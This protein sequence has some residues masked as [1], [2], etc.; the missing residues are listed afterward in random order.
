MNSI[1]LYYSQLPA[2]SRTLPAFS[3]TRLP[4]DSPRQFLEKLNEAACRSRT[5]KSVKTRAKSAPSALQIAGPITGAA[6]AAAA[7]YAV[8]TVVRG[9]ISNTFATQ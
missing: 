7:A 8:A 5:G 9:D 3:R 4:T 6:A 1:Y 2:F